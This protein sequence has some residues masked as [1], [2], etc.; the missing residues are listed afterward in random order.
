MLFG[1]DTPLH[2]D[3]ETT[4][5]GAEEIERPVLFRAT[6]GRVNDGEVLDGTRGDVDARRSYAVDGL[7]GKECERQMA[8]RVAKLGV[9]RAVPGVDGV[10]S[11]ELAE[12]CG[13]ARAV[14]D[15][16]EIEAGVRDG[17]G[18]VGKLRLI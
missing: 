2:G 7:G 16:D 18:A 10:E 17:P 14:G 11:C 4:G 6:G 13:R 9:I 12:A 8:D 5:G 3:L 1:S 15:A